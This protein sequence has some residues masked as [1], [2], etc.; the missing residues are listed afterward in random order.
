MAL[1]KTS[2]RSAAK[3]IVDDP[4]PVGA[5]PTVVDPQRPKIRPADEIPFRS[6]KHSKAE[7]FGGKCGA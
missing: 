2:K 3:V 5:T 6:R 7:N 1:R 4:E